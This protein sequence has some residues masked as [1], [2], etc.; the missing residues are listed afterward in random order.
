MADA[1]RTILAPTPSPETAPFWDAAMSSVPAL[2]PGWLATMPMDRPSTRARA[3]TNCGAQP[4]RSSSSSP[5]SAIALA[6]PCS[7]SR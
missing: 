4:A 6:T 3:V 2:A 7:I 1:K 5:S